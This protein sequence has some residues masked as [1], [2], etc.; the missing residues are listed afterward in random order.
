MTIYKAPYIIVALDFSDE[1]QA[2][3]LVNQ[4]DPQHCRLK[5]GNEM[6][7]RLGPVWVEQLIQRGF[8]VFLDLK[9]HDIPNTVAQAC[10]SAAALGVWMV[11]LH[12]SGGR[13]MVEAARNA[14]DKTTSGK[15]R[16]LLIGVTV[17]TSM[18]EEDLQEIGLSSSTTEQVQRLTRIGMQAGLDGV[19]CSGQEAALLKAEYGQEICLVVPG[20]RMPTSQPDDQRRTMTPSEAKKAG[21]DYLVIGRPITQALEPIK[22][23]HSIEID[24][25]TKDM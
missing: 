15:Q 10:S 14:L 20:I 25:S 2:I 11:N 16:P 12:L 24:I 13:R 22:I 5:V 4:L 3:T 23:I 8:N 1:K 7:T 9:F 17:L 18:L 19:V 6:F 21:A